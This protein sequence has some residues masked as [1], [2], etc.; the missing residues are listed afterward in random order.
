MVGLPPWS[1]TNYGFHA[2]F[3]LH[4]PD[5]GSQDDYNLQKENLTMNK[6]RFRGKLTTMNWSFFDSSDWLCDMKKSTKRPLSCLFTRVILL[7]K[8]YRLENKMTRKHVSHSK[9]TPDYLNNC[10]T[11]ETMTWTDDKGSDLFQIIKLKWP[12]I[13]SLC[14]DYF[15]G[16]SFFNDRTRQMRLI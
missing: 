13:S 16:W 6:A 8:S 2:G 4:Q 11:F 7:Q 5:R 12:D 9:S 3:N 1:D 15:R 10:W 14:Q